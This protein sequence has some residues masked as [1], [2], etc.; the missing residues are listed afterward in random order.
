MMR[1]VA[2]VARTIEG[3]VF[4]PPKNGSPSTET[5]SI[6]RRFIE[7]L[8]DLPSVST[9][10]TFLVAQS[11]NTPQAYAVFDQNFW[12]G[13]GDEARGFEL[14]VPPSLISML[15]HVLKGNT[16]ASG[17]GPNLAHQGCVQTVHDFLLDRDGHGA[18][19]SFC[20]RAG[21]AG[22]RVRVAS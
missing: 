14:C 15:R 6:G 5:P 9:I 19:E 12:L 22:Q 4:D 11:S 3:V 16:I 17:E 8:D 18:I 1:G 7:L 2:Y 10:R 21:N 13:P 20:Q